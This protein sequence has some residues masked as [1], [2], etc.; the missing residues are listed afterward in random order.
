MEGQPYA[1]IGSAI[2]Y[3]INPI[4]GSHPYCNQ[5]RVLC[6]GTQGPDQID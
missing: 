5:P 4:Y 6:L 3:Q 1:Q 2:S